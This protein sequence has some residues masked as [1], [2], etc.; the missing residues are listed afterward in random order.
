MTGLIAVLLQSCVRLC[1]YVI[2]VFF[3]E[4]DL[5]LE[6]L[7]PYIPMDDD[8]QLRTFD[9]LSPL[10]GNTANSS[11]DVTPVTVF[12][13]TPVQSSATD[14]IKSTTI[15]HETAPKMLVTPAPINP[16][17][18]K[19]P[20]PIISAPTSPYAKT[21]SRTSSPVRTGKGTIDQTDQ[22]S[23]GAPD[24]LTVTFGNR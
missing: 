14:T 5:D 6:M 23:P 16:K 13:Q 11:S 3:Q 12:Q 22:T 21:Q 24:L 10:E 4:T 15:K 20:A 2:V 18:L 17:V 7:A 9:Q 19:D 8:F 1:N